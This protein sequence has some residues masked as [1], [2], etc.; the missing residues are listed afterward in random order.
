LTAVHA[1]IAL[2]RKDLVLYF[3][4]RRA[5]LVTIAAPIAIAAFFGTLFDSG[6]SN[7][8]L[9]IPVA[10]VDQ[11][12]SEISTKI[13]AGMKGDASFD[14]QEIDE[15]AALTLVK[16]GKVR[17]SVVLS[18]GFGDQAARALF[19]PGAKP[20][21]SVYYDPSQAMTLAVV[22]GLLTQHVMETVSQAAFGGAASGKML[23]E[24]RADVSQSQRLS[25]GEKRD[26]FALFD[27]V[28]RM[29]QR[30]AAS[31]GTTSMRLEMPFEAREQAVTS[32]VDRKYNSYAHSFAGMGVQFILFMGI[33]LGVG[34]LLV[35]RL[36]LWKRLRAAPLSKGFLLATLIVSG[37]LTATILLMIM[38][39]VA[40][41]FFGVRIEGSVA[42]FLGVGVAF[43]LLTASFGL[44]IAAL[45]RT[46]EATRGLAIF[47]ILILVMLGGAWVPSFIFPEW[48][49]KISLFVPTRWAVDGLDAMTWR[50][51]G[52][53]AALAPIGVMLA[54]SAL[55]AGLA[56]WRFDWEK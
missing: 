39:A 22:R 11:D 18:K 46:P 54:F 19:R 24:S 37:A 9:R 1:F 30:S 55:F 13:V 48:L 15:A 12:Q 16:Q 2:V 34:V 36:G 3:S 51:L 50:G 28:Q 14:I 29:Q 52:F 21:I 49:Q 31:P 5:L 43:A 6:S 47:A 26:L 33:D 45:G 56:V 25:D 20:A 32:G 23:D 44:M 17:A 27:S 8:P 38:Y 35:R 4:N 41:A 40:I 7:R 42:G 10:V 53:D